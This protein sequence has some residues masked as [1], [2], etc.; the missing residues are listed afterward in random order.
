MNRRAFL[1]ASGG[2]VAAGLLTWRLWPE[3]SAAAGPVTKDEI[4]D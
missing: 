2:A 1:A 3:G 4:G